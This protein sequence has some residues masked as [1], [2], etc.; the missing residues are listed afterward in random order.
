M[1]EKREAVMIGQSK[2]AC[3]GFP[4]DRKTVDGNKPHSGTSSRPHFRYPGLN[5][6]R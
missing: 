6:R 1:V 5:L 4:V 2:N 3:K